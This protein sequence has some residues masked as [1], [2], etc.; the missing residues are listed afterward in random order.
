[1]K[2]LV[3]L[4]KKKEDEKYEIL[5]L[6]GYRLP[7]LDNSSFFDYFVKIGLVGAGGVV[8]KIEWILRKIYR[9]TKHYPINNMV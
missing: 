4:D 8:K 7:K 9:K 2:N 1:M 3:A 5:N 6:L